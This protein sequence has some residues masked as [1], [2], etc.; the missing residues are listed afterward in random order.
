MKRVLL[1]IVVGFFLYLPFSKYELW[2]FLFPALY[3]LLLYPSVRFWFSAGFVFF[4]LSLR[5]VNIASVQYGEIEPLLAYILLF[6]FALF[7][8][9][10]QMA[11][12]I[13][14]WKRVGKGKL[15]LIPLLYTTFEVIRSYFPYGGFPW[16]LLGSVWVN[17]PLLKETLYL[18]KVYI[19]GFLLWLLVYLSL[20]RRFFFIFLLLSFL[21]VFSLYVERSLVKK[22]EK[23]R[24]IKVALVQT[25][26]P[27]QDKLYSER[28]DRYT[29]SILYLIEEAQE[30][31]PDLVVLPESAL[32]I[33]LSDEGRKER[34]KLFELSYRTPILVGLIDIREGLKPY[35]S[36]Y[37]I[38]D[39][40]VVDHYDKI[41]LL[42][43]GEYMPFPFAFLKDIFQAINGMDYTPGDKESPIIYDHVR[44]ATPICFEIAYYD[45]IKK[46]S[47]RADLIAV[48][49][50]DGWFNDS[51]CSAQHFSWARVRAIENGKYILWVNN[52]GDT[53][54]IDPFGK[55]IEKLGYMKRGIL[56]GYVKLVD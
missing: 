41:R 6:L 18:T 17:V 16:L 48:L 20:K 43:I 25:A 1:S 42:P 56:I 26:I 19:M 27:Q 12:P 5:C 36:A 24:E 47:Q 34:M 33:L 2:F 45:L 44:I 3:V 10:Y 40:E 39:G 22:V 38:K 55:V 31:K 49:T 4:T 23:G 9:S 51:D 14:L 29:D 52:S 53:A 54:I 32:P 50:N 30:S 46:L 15:S 35:N 8:S 37:L 7:L 11:L 28:F 21:T 13:Y